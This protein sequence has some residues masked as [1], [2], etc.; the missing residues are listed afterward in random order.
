MEQE[1]LP[2]IS[3]AQPYVVV[4][5]NLRVCLA[6]LRD[7]DKELV[8]QLNVAAAGIQTSVPKAVAIGRWKSWDKRKLRLTPSA[9]P[10]GCVLLL[11]F[12]REPCCV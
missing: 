11:S 9:G 4:L 10:A 7:S 6:A 12:C 3:A 8:N 5:N 1:G 2:L